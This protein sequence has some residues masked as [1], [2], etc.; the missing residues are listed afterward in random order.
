MRHRRSLVNLRHPAC[1]LQIID[2]SVGACMSGSKVCVMDRSK[3]ADANENDEKGTDCPTCGCSNWSLADRIELRTYRSSSRPLS[4]PKRV[5]LRPIIPPDPVLIETP[6][7]SD[8][9]KLYIAFFSC[10]AMLPVFVYATVQLFCE[11]SVLSAPAF[12]SWL[13]VDAMLFIA[14]SLVWF[15]TGEVLWPPNHRTNSMGPG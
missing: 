14:V 2:G 9:T 12:F 7:V 11:W 15:G 10:I 3:F 1:A 4:E 5:P 13:T 8:R 6:M